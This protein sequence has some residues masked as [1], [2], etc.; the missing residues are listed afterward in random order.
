LVNKYTQVFLCFWGYPEPTVLTVVVIIDNNY[1]G[2][3][4]MSKI[5]GIDDNDYKVA[6]GRL[7]V[8]YTQVDVYGETGR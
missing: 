8:M 2:E 6:M 5:Q 1:R 3:S 4:E 7:L